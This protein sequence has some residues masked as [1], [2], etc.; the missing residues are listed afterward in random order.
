VIHRDVKPA[1]VMI[2]E[3]GRVVL[4]DFGVARLANDDAVQT[5]T[6]AMLGTPA[7]MS[8]EQ[9]LAGEI[10]ARSDVYSL[11]AA[12]YQLATGALPYSGATPV[13]LAA[14]VRG[15]LPPPLRKNPGMGR[16]LAR[17]IE[18]AM[19]REPADRFDAAGAL[20][21]ELERIAR[22]AGFTDGDAELAKYFASPGEWNERALPAIVSATFTR[23]EEAAKKKERARAVALAERVLALAPD[24]AAAN[25]L[26][27]SIGA[28][29]RRWRRAAVISAILAGCAVVVLASVAVV[30]R[31]RTRSTS[32]APVI[33]PDAATPVALAPPP[34]IDAAPPPIVI[35]TAPDAAPSSKITR[36]H[37]SAHVVD[38]GAPAAITV[39]TPDAAPPPLEDALLTVTILPWCEITLDDEP[40]GRSP[41]KTALHVRPGHHDLRCTQSASGTPFTQSFDL[42]PGQSRTI[43]GDLRP[44][45]TVRVDIPGTTVTVDGTVRAA[46]ASFSLRT[47]RYRVH[48]ERKGKSAEDGYVDV[49]TVPCTIRDTPDLACYE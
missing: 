38:A 22:A 49:S 39:I 15:D 18:R 16:E 48:V 35:A 20:A 14:V 1:N 40:R 17:A 9:A 37:V 28:G 44:A 7:F 5:Q 33:V 36:V 41:T 11:G 6:G 10:D 4:C 27:G 24:H 23:A 26:L 8:P 42:A 3:R 30:G 12:L 21:E 31:S 13:V 34:T 45:V 43:T 29:A 47:G 46:G 2:T 25:A 32:S 19:A